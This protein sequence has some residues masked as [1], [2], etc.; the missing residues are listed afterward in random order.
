MA[1]LLVGGTPSR[2]SDSK[3]PIYNISCPLAL[4]NPMQ[5]IVPHGMC[6]SH[7]SSEV[8][9]GAISIGQRGFINDRYKVNPVGKWGKILVMAMG[10]VDH[11]GQCDL[12]ISKNKIELNSQFQN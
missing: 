7:F 12:P 5:G 1:I 11:L 9:N 4:N 6:C 3:I 8:C 2:L 10:F